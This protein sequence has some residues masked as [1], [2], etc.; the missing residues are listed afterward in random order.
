MSTLPGAK[1]PF[2]ARGGWWVVMQFILMP[3]VIAVGWFLPGN[4]HPLPARI[5]ATVALSIGAFL[6][7]GGALHLGANR[8][9]FP[10]PLADGE[11]VQ[12][13]VYGWVRHPLY[14]AL[15]FLSAGWAL[16]HWSWPAA[17]AGLALAILLVAKA[18]R[19]ELWLR[20]K[21]PGYVD[22]SHRVRRFIPALW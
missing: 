9:A 17:L 6:G 19:E 14:S 12:H 11:L 7:I 15:M 21:Y 22:Y 16:W 18:D 13:G 10:A 1:N 5:A 20:E 3:T 8:T 2:A 4:S